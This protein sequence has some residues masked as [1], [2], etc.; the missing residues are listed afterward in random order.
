M[1]EILTGLQNIY[2]FL[3][4]MGINV[5]CIAAVIGITMA[6]KW[7]FPKIFEGSH[8][9]ILTMGIALGLGIGSSVGWAFLTQAVNAEL[10]IQNSVIN[11]IASGYAADILKAV[12]KYFKIGENT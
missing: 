9:K 1:N 12:M 5:F 2:E 10:I 3:Q 11:T 4:N 7:L 6:I 8:K